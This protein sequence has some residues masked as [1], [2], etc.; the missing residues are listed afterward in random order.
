MREA[1]K[2]L[3]LLTHL[4]RA[5][6]QGHGIDIGC[7]DDPIQPDALPFDVAQGDANC[8]TDYVA[9]LGAFDYVF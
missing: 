8:V 6:L 7:G 1:S 4:E 2:T 5:L 3:G 9:T